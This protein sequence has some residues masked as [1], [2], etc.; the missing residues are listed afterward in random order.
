MIE[1]SRNLELSA[2]SPIIIPT[3]PQQEQQQQQR[4]AQREEQKKNQQN[5][6]QQQHQNLNPGAFIV[7]FT[8][9]CQISSILSNFDVGI[10]SNL[11][12]ISVAVGNSDIQAVFSL[13][14]LYR[15]ITPDSD[16]DDDLLEGIQFETLIYVISP[17]AKIIHAIIFELLR[18]VILCGLNCLKRHN[19][20]R[21]STETKYGVFTRI[22]AISVVLFLLEQP[23]IIANL[24][25]YLTC[26]K[27][28]PYAPQYYIKSRNNIEC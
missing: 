19:N 15:L 26:T 3:H 7:I 24:T 11:I 4:E 6:Q 21:A 13:Q 20:N 8:T 12:S 18:S 25:Q 2:I 17:L 1:P 10:A 23:A 28:D 14:C 27:L 22:G 16:N 5:S 9:F